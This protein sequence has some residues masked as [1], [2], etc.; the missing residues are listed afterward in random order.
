[1]L[2]TDAA[3]SVAGGVPRVSLRHKWHHRLRVP[4]T[5]PT[6]KAFKVR[7]AWHERYGVETRIEAT[8]PD[9]AIA[10]AERAML[11][12]SFNFPTGISN[13]DGA[14]DAHVASVVEIGN[15]IEP[16]DPYLPPLEKYCE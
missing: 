16:D 14:D 5:Q 3:A 13:F 4:A 12:G 11:D 15:G 10:V 7:L 8:S 6:T 2:H 1:M 9:E